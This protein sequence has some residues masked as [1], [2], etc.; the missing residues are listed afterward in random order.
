MNWKEILRTRLSR[1]WVSDDTG[2]GFVGARLFQL[3]ADLNLDLSYFS[4]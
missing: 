1:L 3:S 4:L 2:V